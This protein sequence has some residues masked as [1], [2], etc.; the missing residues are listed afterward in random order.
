MTASRP[1]E[2]VEDPEYFRD[3]LNSMRMIADKNLRRV[4]FGL[5]GDGIAPHY[6]ITVPDGDYMEHSVRF[7]INGLTHH[8]HH[9]SPEPFEVTNLTEKFSW[10]D[11]I[12][13][14]E[15]ALSRKRE[16]K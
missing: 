8:T 15:R 16:R 11:V 14:L 1:H 5:T 10:D 7:P 4:R 13:M 6:E 12:G 3:V 9:Q 2:L